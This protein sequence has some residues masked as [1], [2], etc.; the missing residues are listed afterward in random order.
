MDR[1]QKIIAASGL[2]SRRKAEE[3]ILQGR[4]KV[5]GQVVTELGVKPRK[6]ALIEVD[7]KAIAREDKVYYVMNKP[8]KVLC[9]LNDEHDRRTVVDLMTDV[10][11]RVF[12]VG[13]LDYDTTGVLIMTNDGEFA[14]EIIHPRYHIAKVYEVTINGILKTEEIK[15]LEQGVVLDDGIKTLPAKLWVTNKD[16]AHEQTMFELTIQEGR[17]RQIKRMLEVFGY[18]VR[19]LHRRSLGP[20]TVRGLNPGEYRLM[21]PF[22]V[23][24]LRRLANEGRLK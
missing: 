1:L 2:T 23:K 7:G 24:Q 4:V 15:Q 3:W 22:E 9:T 12:P 18:E 16:F 17:N 11:Q 21:K 10:P 8:K 14:N 5:D 19:R 6:G 13:R 20:I